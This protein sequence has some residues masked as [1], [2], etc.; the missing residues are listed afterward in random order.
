MNIR[1]DNRIEV[2]KFR[3]LKMR[4]DIKMTDKTV[5]R[6]YF[7]SEENPLEETPC[8]ENFPEIFSG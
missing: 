2:E 1:C 7:F 6:I 4:I 8:K 3:K 5:F